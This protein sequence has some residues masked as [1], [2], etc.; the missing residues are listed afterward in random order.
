MP[1]KLGPHAQAGSADLRRFVEAG[2]PLVRLDGDLGPARELLDV[3][4]DLLI[5]ARVP[6]D[7]TAELEAGGQPEASA[8]AFVE[9]QR[10]HHLQHPHLTVWEGP[11]APALG[12]AND[13]AA[14]RRMAWY[15]AFEAERLRLLADL[16]VRGVVGNFAAGAPDLPLWAAFL[17]AL[18]AAERHHGYLG[19][20]EYSSPFMWS[21]TG[22]H[23]IANCD[24]E[25]VPGE[26]DTGWTT[27]RY[28]KVYRG[29]LAANGLEAVPVVILGCG[30]DRIGLVCPGQGDGPWNAHLEFWHGHDGARDPI[31]YWRGP[32][33]DPE[34]YYA[35]QLLWYE[36][37]LQQDPFIVGAAVSVVGA[38]EAWASFEIAGTGVAEALINHIQ[39]SQ[40]PAAPPRAHVVSPERGDGTPSPD[41]SVVVPRVEGPGRAPA[42]ATGAGAAT[43]VLANLLAN[44]GF[45]DGQAYFADETRERSVPAGW[46]LEYAGVDAPEL[47]GQSG[48][49]GRPVTA[50]INRKA[51]VAEE[52]DRI[53]AGG[54]FCWK[55]S[56]TRT[57]VHVRLW[58]AVDGLD[59]AHTYRFTVNVLP[60]AIVRAQ[61]RPTYAADALAAEVRLTADVGGEQADSGWQTGQDMAYG[62]YH[63]LTLDF[64]PVGGRA[65]VAVEVR[66]RYPLPLGAWYIDEL[67]VAAA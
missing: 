40:P 1:S 16:G 6:D 33:R 5:I 13:P 36:R 23:Q 41:R 66:S 67:S 28:R 31:D 17:P 29:A 15:A 14:M 8:L 30:L 12:H 45:E 51:I 25:A 34:R 63:R 59:P 11:D 37:E 9:R 18:D 58:Q 42:R 2:C 55:V 27:L 44:A 56:G 26:G 48:P 3:R 53:F 21:L 38:A 35:E 7:V 64:V 60:D 49:F 57:P 4:R 20:R 47:P 62:R 10:S 61:P 65:T 39:S 50:L 46:R 19:L 22:A 32:G 52:R 24:G 43:T 54:D